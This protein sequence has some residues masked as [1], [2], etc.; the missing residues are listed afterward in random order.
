MAY[1]SDPSRPS[2]MVFLNGQANADPV[3][4]FLIS[5]RGDQIDEVYV[6]SQLAPKWGGTSY[7]VGPDRD[8][9]VYWTATDGRSVRTLSRGVLNYSV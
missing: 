2:L 9:Y 3:R 8:G 4:V 6:D 5:A 7:I 1:Q